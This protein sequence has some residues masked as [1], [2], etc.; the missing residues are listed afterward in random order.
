LQE[1]KSITNCLSTWDSGIEKLS[2]LIQ[3]KKQQ[4]K[5]L[6]QQLLTGKKRL[7]GF[8]G[9]WKEVRLD[10]YF[11]E[12]KIK[13]ES[14]NKNRRISV[15]L[16]LEGINKREVRGTEADSTQFYLR[17]AGQFIYGKQNFHNGSIGLIPE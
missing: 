13:S 15:R 12:S 6:M 16:H 17:K 5:G 1:Q 4:K 9:E 8:E 3:A 14:N 2:Q 7:A 10:K 11:K